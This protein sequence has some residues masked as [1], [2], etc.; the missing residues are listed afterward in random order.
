[1]FDGGGGD[2]ELFEELLRVEELSTQV[3]LVEEQ[4]QQLE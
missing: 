4:E 2:R 1:V 3:E